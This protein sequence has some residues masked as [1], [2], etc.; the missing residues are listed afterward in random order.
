[1]TAEGQTA[2]WMTLCNQ[3]RPSFDLQSQLLAFLTH[4]VLDTFPITEDFL[5]QKANTC[6]IQLLNP[7]SLGPHPKS[8]MSILWKKCDEQETKTDITS[9][10]EH[11]RWLTHLSELER[12]ASITLYLLQI[13]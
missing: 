3:D 8:Y 9:L 13:L 1:M 12:T 11:S 5:V 7:K 4:E 6:P 2:W 10:R